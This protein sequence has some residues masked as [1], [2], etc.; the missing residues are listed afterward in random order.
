MV[1][2]PRFTELEIMH[3]FVHDLSA[4]L[5]YYKLYEIRMSVLSRHIYNS[6]KGDIGG[7]WVARSVEHP[8]LDFG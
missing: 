3:P 6:L 2:Y 4:S 1:K 5:L 8:T 7:P